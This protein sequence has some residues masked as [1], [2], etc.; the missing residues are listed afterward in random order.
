MSLLDE[1]TIEDLDCE[2]KELAECIGLTA[3]KNLIQTYA[4]S[5]IFIRMPG[6]ITINLRNNEIRKKFNGYNYR[7]LAREYRLTERS[8][9]KIVSEKTKP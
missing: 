7:T 8:I 3:Y 9:R 2:Q 6:R 4:G 1:L 5:Y